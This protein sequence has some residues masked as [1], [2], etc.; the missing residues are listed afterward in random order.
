MVPRSL[1]LTPKRVTFIFKPLL[2]PT[3]NRQNE[4]ISCGSIHPLAQLFKQLLWSHPQKASFSLSLTSSHSRQPAFSTFSDS[5]SPYFQATEHSQEDICLSIVYLV[6]LNPPGSSW[7][8]ASSRNL[9]LILKR[10]AAK[11]WCLLHVRIE[12]KK[13]QVCGRYQP[14]HGWRLETSAKNW[15]KITKILKTIQVKIN[16]SNSALL[17]GLGIILNSFKNNFIPSCVVLRGDSTFP[18]LW[19]RITWPDR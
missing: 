3:N 12:Q 19:M 16:K 5:C 2:A 13:P 15:G 9:S 18:T 4:F 8:A 10:G 14:S 17:L 6:P 1:S 7:D 11:L